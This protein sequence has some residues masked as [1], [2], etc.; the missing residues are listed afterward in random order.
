MK[1]ILSILLILTMILSFAA[2]GGDD[3]DKKKEKITNDL[4]IFQSHNTPS[5]T[6][7]SES[8]SKLA[9]P[10]KNETVGDCVVTVDFEGVS[11]NDFTIGPSSI[12]TDFFNITNYDYDGLVLEAGFSAFVSFGFR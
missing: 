2:C 8:T 10:F 5:F 1:K 4:S 7:K 12:G 3:S 9:F 6:T 11:S